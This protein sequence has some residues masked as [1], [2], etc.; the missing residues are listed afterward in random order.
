MQ[1]L[2]IK[3]CR[4][5]ELK[6]ISHL[7]T[8]R[9]WSRAFA[10][11]GIDIAYSEGFNPHPKIAIAAPMATGVTGSAELMDIVYTANY[12]STYIMQAVNRKLP[13]GIKVLQ[14]HPIPIEK[15]SLQALIEQAEYEVAIKTDKTEDEI[16]LNIDN[17]LSL[18]ELPWQEQKQEKI[19]EYDLRVLIIDIKLIE[20]KEGICLLHMALVCNNKGSGRPEQILKALGFEE[21]PR[22]INREKLLLK[23]S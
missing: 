9:L 15:P 2:R 11:A 18:E 21:Y 16:H 3:F 4:G 1:R 17:L 10:R 7:D 19:K 6:Y 23:T 20:L 8:M 13:E 5:E 22:K 12:S 14:V